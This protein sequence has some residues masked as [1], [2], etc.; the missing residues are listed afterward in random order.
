M[1]ETFTFYI[2]PWY[3]KSPYFEATKR[4]GCRSW[5]LYNHM[6]LPTLYDDPVTEYWAL[7]RDVT[8]WDVAV[9]R[10]VE[11]TGP[12]AF[13]FTNLLTCQDLTTCDVDQCKYVLLTSRRAWIVNASRPAATGRGSVL[14][15]VGGLRRAVVREGR[16]G[17]RRARRGHRGGRRLA[18]A[19]Q[20]PRSKDVTAALFGEDVAGLRTTAARGP[21]S[22]ASRS[23]SR[24]PAGPARWGS[25]STC[26]THPRRRAVAARRGGGGA[27]RDPRDRAVGG[28]D[29]GGDL[30]LRL[31]PPA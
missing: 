17:L 10:C 27:V 16:G 7:L 21:R 14:A 25:A 26:A 31:G 28:A 1:P 19:G 6:L 18:D 8:M 9:E 29:R 2:Q 15:R 24:A 20:G 12:D 4:A 13:A 30:Q 22:R 23:S 11:I 5:G 3:R